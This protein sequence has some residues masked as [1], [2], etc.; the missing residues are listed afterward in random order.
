MWLPFTFLLVGIV[1]ADSLEKWADRAIKAGL[2]VLLLGMGIS[3]GS[4][5]TLLKA[6][7]RLGLESVLFCLC[8][9]LVSIILVLAWEKLI[10]KESS[11]AHAG[12]VTDPSDEYKFIILVIIC[13]FFGIVMGEQT[14]L[15][16]AH[17]TNIII[18]I[19]LI[20]IY[21][22]IGVGLRLAV[23]K[24]FKAKTE[25][26]MYLLLPVLITVGSVTGGVIAGFI[27]R[28]NLHYSA[29]IGGGMAYYSLAT[30]MITDKAGLDIGLVALISNFLREFITF[31]LVP[32]LARFSNLAPIALGAASTMDTTL[33]VMK[34]NIS[35]KFTLVAFF[36]GVILSFVVPALLL[37]LLGTS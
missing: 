24:L 18:D 9:C 12:T 29:A 8:S 19:A 14:D 26:L 1:F 35:E 20:S 28:E 15:I 10:V 21:I 25:F 30:A 22:G 34:Q 36:N 2:T 32:F 23:Q 33:V 13:L 17:A 4:D 7:P 16:S 6:I 5:Q 11:Y 3:V 31:L 37:I 27:M